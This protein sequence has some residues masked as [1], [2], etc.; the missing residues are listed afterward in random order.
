M[1]RRRMQILKDVTTKE[2]LT[3]AEL[4]AMHGVS[5][6][7]IRSD[8]RALE[9]QGLLKRHHGGASSEK[10]ANRINENYEVK[11][12]IARQAANI[13]EQGETIMIESGSTNALLAQTLAEK[14]D[15]TIITNSYFIANFVS[16]YPRARIILLG[17]DYLV[18]S[19]VCVGPLTIRSLRSFFVDKLF[20]SCNGFSE[21]IGFTSANLQR[22]DVAVEMAKQANRS[23]ILTDSGKFRRRGVAQQLDLTQVDTVITD[24]GI[25]D[26]TEAVLRRAGINVIM[27]A[28]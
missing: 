28:V 15:V 5:Q 3:V 18:H 8:L 1:R 23:I 26:H 6:V 9:Q 24:E 14:K 25:D 21:K 10:I 27:V 19:E 12:R 22:A 17:G 7:T 4:S 20:V 2:T 13:V 16:G 11:L